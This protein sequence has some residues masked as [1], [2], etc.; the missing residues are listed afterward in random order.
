M[1]HLWGG[2]KLETSNLDN[3]GTALDMEL[4][5]SL[6]ESQQKVEDTARRILPPLSPFARNIKL[7]NFGGGGTPP[8]V[9]PH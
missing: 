2:G 4:I 3:S 5:F 9:D 7:K 8:K 1:V 6:F